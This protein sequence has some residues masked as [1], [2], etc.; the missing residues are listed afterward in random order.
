MNRRRFTRRHNRSNHVESNLHRIINRVD[1][2]KDAIHTQVPINKLSLEFFHD[3]ANS[4][5]GNLPRDSYKRSYDYII[6]AANTYE[7]PKKYTFQCMQDVSALHTMDNFPTYIKFG[8][9]DAGLSPKY[10][11]P[12]IQL[13]ITPGS[14]LDPAPR[15]EGEIFADF[16]KNLIQSDFISIGMQNIKQLQARLNS[17]KGC[18]IALAINHNTINTEFDSNFNAINGDIQYFSGNANKNKW[19]NTEGNTDI[20]IASN[21]IVCKELGDTLQTYYGLKYLRNERIS[22]KL[23]CVFT[24]DNIL[25]LRCKIFQ[26][27][28]MHSHIRDVNT[29]IFYFYPEMC[30]ITESFKDMYRKN[31]QL[32]NANVIENVQSVLNRKMFFQING[33]ITRFSDES[34]IA[35]MLRKCIAEIEFHTNFFLVLIVKI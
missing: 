10:Y 28:V 16:D 9:H 6:S 22:S 19:F 13:V 3:I 24:N 31:I 1:C 12:K 5:F 15:S 4:L 20:N 7:S 30:E 23:I 2:E 21:F 18:N 11:L 29:K 8:I 26:I 27:P 25:A 14:Y 17:I 35:T 33:K 34:E 32:K